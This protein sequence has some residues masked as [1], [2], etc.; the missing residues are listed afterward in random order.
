MFD[1]FFRTAPFG[2]GFT[3]ASGLELGLH[4]FKNKLVLKARGREPRMNADGDRRV[5]HREHKDRKA[6]SPTRNREQGEGEV[7]CGKGSL[8]KL[9]EE[10]VVLKPP[11]AQVFENLGEF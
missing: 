7:D 3:V 5:S 11:V 6:E 4:D 10:A 2:S 8:T 9:L 1:L